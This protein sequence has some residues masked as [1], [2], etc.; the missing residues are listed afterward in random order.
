MP[1]EESYPGHLQRLLDA[2]EPGAFLVINKGIPGFN[3]SMVRKRLA[4]QV[5]R[6]TPDVV[7]LWAGINDTWNL[8][9]V[10]VTGRTLWEHLQGIVGRL[11]VYRFVRVWL[12]HRTLPR[13]F[14]HETRRPVTRGTKLNRYIDYGDEIESLDLQRRDR[15]VDEEMKE[16]LQHNYRAIIHQL[17]AEGIPVIFVAYPVPWKDFA[18]V[19]RVI[20]DVTEREDVPMVR[21][22]ESIQRLPPERRKLLPGAHPN[23]PMYGEIARDIVPVVLRVRARIR[24]QNSR[25][26]LR[27]LRSRRLSESAGVVGTTSRNS[28]L[29]SGRRWREDEM[30]KWEVIVA[31]AHSRRGA[32][33]PRLLM[34]RIHARFAAS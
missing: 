20:R 28:R 23:G 31:R 4:D 7:I 25:S 9:D 10:E 12:H 24:S 26:D 6:Y 15:H 13:G 16:R 17:R 8:T 29:R 21:S 30:R 32:V 14:A 18:T 33:A 19:N 11:R 3:T 5:V 2:D 34:T 27:Q 22:W 1:E